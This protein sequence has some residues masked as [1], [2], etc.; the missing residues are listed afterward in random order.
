[1]N[2]F[3]IYEIFHYKILGKWSDLSGCETKFRRKDMRVNIHT[4]TIYQ[5]AFTLNKLLTVCM[6]SRPCVYGVCFSSVY[7]I[8]H[9]FTSIG[10]IL[11]L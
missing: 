10:N 5:Y 3:Y 6:L 1:M 4:H 11:R 8:F 2:F 7:G 9:E